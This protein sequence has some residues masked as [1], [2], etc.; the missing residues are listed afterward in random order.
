MLTCTDIKSFEFIM[1]AFPDI[2]GKLRGHIIPISHLSDIYEGV[3]FDGSSIPFTG[4]EKSDMIFRASKREKVRKLP[5]CRYR[6]GIVFGEVYWPDGK[7][8]DVYPRYIA[9]KFEEKLKSSGIA[10]KVA[11]EPEFYLLVAESSQNSESKIRSV[12]A[13]RRNGV[14]FYINP[15]IDNTLSFQQEISRFLVSQGIDVE[16]TH[17]EVGP[18]QIEITFK[19]GGIVEVS[20]NLLYLKQ[21]AKQL[22]KRKGWIA[23]FMPKINPQLAGNGLHV[24]VNL[25]DSK[26]RNIFCDSNDRYGLSQTAYYFIG[27]ILYY[28]S[29]I[30][31]LLAPTVNSYKRLVSFHEA[32]THI[33]YGPFNRSALI[34]IPAGK[35][36]IEVR[37]PD[38]SM[39]PYIGLVAIVAAGLRGVKKTIQPP[40]PLERNAYKEEG[41]P[42]LP[43]TLSEAIERAES[44]GILRETFGKGFV[45]TYLILRKRELR[46]FEN[47]VG[48]FD[49][50]E[51]SQW[52]LQ[53]YLLDV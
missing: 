31:V 34:R 41:I 38:G 6:T 49:P 46:E 7:P 39:N 28:A 20:D 32:P 12:D 21:V 30:A 11:L 50:G 8:V 29:E 19:Y 36:K 17:H 26:G 33:C 45:E 2:E 25:V 27:G 3:P 18:G 52:E 51:V 42:Q 15:L 10:P 44:S 48:R 24:H 16:R 47:K 37:F 40:E 43:S 14:Y 13:V 53:R 4:I 5:G 35:A 23:T 22:A 9:R 1:I